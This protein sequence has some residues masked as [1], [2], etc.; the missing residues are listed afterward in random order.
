MGLKGM[1]VGVRLDGSIDLEIA[2][3]EDDEDGWN[4]SNVS[5]EEAE[6]LHDELGRAIARQRE[7]GFPKPE[8]AKP[9][10]PEPGPPTS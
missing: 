4:F 5:L 9:A 7:R 1:S 3:E 6:F 10:L 8:P 2:R